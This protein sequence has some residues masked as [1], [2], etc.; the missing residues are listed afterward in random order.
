[1]DSQ[2]NMES[3]VKSTVKKASYH[4]RNIGRVRKL[5]DAEATKKVMQSLV[6][7]RIDYCN[8]LLPGLH[9]STLQRLQRLQNSA[10][11]IVTKTRKYEHITP[12]L[13]E[14]HWLPVRYRIDFKILLLVFKSFHGQA[15]EYI[16]EL[17]I[18]YKP[19][20]PLRSS[21]RSL[22]IQPKS[23]LVRAGDRA[24]SRYAPRLWN[25]L[26]ENLKDSPSVPAFKR[27]LKTY[28]YKLAFSQSSC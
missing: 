10:A 14:L 16:T 8:A 5:L 24:F 27:N 13:E 11:R 18:Q 6:I 28:F 19:N 9:E 12:V 1:M 17:L 2:L 26:P 7:S 21:D 15:P 3:H 25:R 4:L 22:L 23:R 20:R